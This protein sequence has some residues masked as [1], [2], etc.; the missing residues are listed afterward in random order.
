MSTREEWIQG[1]RDFAN[2]LET[3]EAP[4]P[5]QDR[6]DVFFE[7]K[8]EL[9]KAV[10]QA[11]GSFEKVFL[12]EWLALRRQFGPLRYELNIQREQVCKLVV[13]GTKEVAERVIPAQVI[14]AHSEDI[15]AWECS[16]PILESR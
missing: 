9:V 16:E 4:L 10:K 3:S 8:E 11:G 6:F 2:F 5:G 14:P 15:T 7:S 1:L 12:G 13:T